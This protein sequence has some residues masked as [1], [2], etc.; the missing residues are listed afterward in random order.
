MFPVFVERKSEKLGTLHI[1]GIF[2]FLY[3][4]MAETFLLKDFQQQNL[5]FIIALFSRKK[6][7]KIPQ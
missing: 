2:Y 3:H 5:F 4:S 6:Y 1:V 7:K